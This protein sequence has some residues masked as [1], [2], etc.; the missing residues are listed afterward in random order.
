MNNLQNSKTSQSIII[1]G[2]SGSGKTETTKHLLRFL[3]DGSPQNV[4][5]TVDRTNKLLEAFGNSK[6]AENCNSSR[7]I[8]CVQVSM[9]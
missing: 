3:S 5:Q 2:E 4:I 7:F 8:K 6:T 9:V 1:V